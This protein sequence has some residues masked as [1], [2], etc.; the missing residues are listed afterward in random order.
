MVF[1][2]S[3]PLDDVGV[4]SY[5]GVEGDFHGDLLGRDAAMFD[6]IAFVDELDGE[7]WLWSIERD[8]LLDASS[9]GGTQ[10]RVSEDVLMV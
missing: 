6:S 4:L 7:Y 8:C 3:E 5:K 9:R 1:A 10:P 2:S